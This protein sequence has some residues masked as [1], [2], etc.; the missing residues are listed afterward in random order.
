M[1]RDTI[2]TRGKIHVKIN[3]I[4]A[5]LGNPRSLRHYWFASNRLNKSVAIIQQRVISNVWIVQMLKSCRN[6]KI[7]QHNSS[8]RTQQLEKWILNNEKNRHSKTIQNT[9]IRGLIIEVTQQALTNKV[10][11]AKA[12]VLTKESLMEICQS[13][14]KICWANFEK[15]FNIRSFIGTNRYWNAQKKIE[16]TKTFSDSKLLK[17][18]AKCLKFFLEKN[19]FL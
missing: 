2:D 4:P 1:L 7:P 9:S 12:S 11:Y 18:M 15:I 17:N 8:Y 13:V 5:S 16:F 10:S 19:G 3:S 14:L 6:T